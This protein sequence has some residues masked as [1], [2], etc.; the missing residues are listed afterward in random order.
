[1]TTLLVPDKDC[2]KCKRLVKFRNSNR[3]LFTDWY[4]SP[5]PSFGNINSVLLIVGLAPGLKGANRT[6]R[7]F[8][9]DY[10]GDLLY[11][12][13]IK[14]GWA[15]GVYNKSIDSNLNLVNCRITNAVRCVPPQ[16]KPELIEKNNCF[17]FLNNE[18]HNLPKLRY[19]IALGTIAHKAVIKCFNLKQKDYKFLHGKEYKLPNNI[20]LF[21]SYHCSR[22]NINTKRLTKE[23]FEKIFVNL[24]R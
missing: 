2:Q 21:D 15:V 16:N 11:P 7:P 24:P 3:Q 22:Y 18:I 5:V 17:G 20:N 8:T 19:I 9:G 1:M 23:M 14:F 4:N 10:A 12:T 6:G 13:L